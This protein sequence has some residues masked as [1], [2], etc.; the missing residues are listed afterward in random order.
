MVAMAKIHAA[1]F[2]SGF[3]FLLMQYLKNKHSDKFIKK[4]EGAW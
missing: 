1:S 4:G 2:Q 3:A